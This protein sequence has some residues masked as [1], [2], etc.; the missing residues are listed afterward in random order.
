MYAE[1]TFFGMGVSNS[2]ILEA[3]N[4]GR[5]DQCLH[6]ERGLIQEEKDGTYT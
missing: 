3:P 6:V 2:R 1:P 5:K 4:K